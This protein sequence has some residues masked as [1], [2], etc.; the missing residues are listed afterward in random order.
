MKPDYRAQMIALWGVPKEMKS[1]QPKPTGENTMNNKFNLLNYTE[2]WKTDSHYAEGIFKQFNEVS[3]EL[4]E[5]EE[6]TLS[7]FA[8]LKTIFSRYPKTTTEF[9]TQMASDYQNAVEVAQQSN[10]SHEDPF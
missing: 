10:R 3:K 6:I 9:I 5:I 2:L 4:L 7:E 1:N 8:N